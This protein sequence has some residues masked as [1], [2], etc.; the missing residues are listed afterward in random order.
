MDL[1]NRTTVAVADSREADTQV[2]K[3]LDETEL[4]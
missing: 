2:A 4:D 1:I 3:C